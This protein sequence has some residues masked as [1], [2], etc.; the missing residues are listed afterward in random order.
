MATYSVSTVGFGSIYA[1]SG[2]VQYNV[3]VDCINAPDGVVHQTGGTTS[4]LNIAVQVFAGRGAPEYRVA[5][6]FG[7]ADLAAYQGNITSLDFVIDGIAQVNP[8]NIIVCKS[9]AFGGSPSNTLNPTDMAR[10]AFW[11]PNTPYST[12]SP[13]GASQFTITGNATAIADANAQGFINFV[14]IDHLYDYTGF[15]PGTSAF[16]SYHTIDLDPAKNFAEGNYTVPGYANKVNDVG[17]GNIG[18]VI[19][20]ASSNVSLVIGV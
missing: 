7:I 20:V 2:A 18:E 10:G 3:W 11:D 17:P 15:S 4:T 13:G 19:G 6:T 12:S 9:D 16:S 5:R 14:I 8:G 1:G